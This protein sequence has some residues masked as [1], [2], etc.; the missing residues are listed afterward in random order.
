MFGN[1]NDL[2]TSFDL[3]LP[4]GVFLALTSRGPARAFYLTVCLLLV[5]GVVLT[6]SRSGFL[7][8]LAVA[9]V[10]LWKMGRD[11]RALTVTVFIIL[12]GIFTVAS[13]QGYS[14]RLLSM[15]NIESDP[16]GSA[17]LRRDQLDRA[18][19]MAVSRP[20]I[21]VGLGNYHIYA[22][23]EQRAH[24]SYL[25]I[26]AELGVAGLIAYLIL[27]FAPLR[28][29]V[30]VERETTEKA[31]A[32][33]A[34]SHRAARSTGEAPANREYRY[35]SISLQAAMAAYLVCS[36]FASLQYQWYLYYLVA[37]AIALV[38]LYEA[39][40]IGAN[41]EG[42]VKEKQKVKGVA[43]RKS[44]RL[45]VSQAAGQGLPYSD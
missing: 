35:M 44:R 25:E 37:Y 41:P 45:A 16:T 12:L 10:M 2:A 14:A 5:T 39:A 32:R 8:L 22:L 13:P 34:R 19:D 24:N 43:W 1:P 26:S 42:T 30:R 15:F 7:G 23:R 18:F 6:F 17:Q 33:A 20:V 28:A 11:S 27:L 9:G 40:K 3:L 21:G 4:L 29:L 38:K 31:P 36:F